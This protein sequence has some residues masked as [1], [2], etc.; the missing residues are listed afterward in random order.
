MFQKRLWAAAAI[1]AL[2]VIAGFALS[3]PRARD[4]VSPLAFTSA[5]ASVPVVTIRESY[6]KG[7]RTISGSVESPDA[8]TTVSVEAF[9]EGAASTTQS[10]ILALSMPETSGI[11][12]KVPTPVP[13]SVSLSAPADAPLI[14]TL[15]GA[16]ASTT[17]P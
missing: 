9:L 12:L 4:V 14:V 16:P 2:V 10:V 6:K 17:K 5:E 7:V 1:I 3:V 8:C 15:N 11:C 13:F